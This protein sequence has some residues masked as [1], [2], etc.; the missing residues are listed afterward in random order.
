[1]GCDMSVAIRKILADARPTRSDAIVKL[2]TKVADV[3]AELVRAPGVLGIDLFGSV[4]RGDASPLSDID[5]LVVA[6]DRSVRA[7]ELRRLVSPR[8][9]ERLSLHVFSSGRFENR[10][11]TNALFMTHLRAEG[12]VLYDPFR[13]IADALKQTA[14]VSVTARELRLV[15]ARLRAYDDA[16]RFG[17][18]YLLPLSHLY[19]LGKRAAMLRLHEMS[20]HEYGPLKVFET[21]RILVPSAD[22]ATAALTELRPFNHLVTGRPSEALPY[23]FHNAR[24]QFEAAVRAVAD[25]ARG[26]SL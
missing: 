4:A 8:L 12:I 22:A 18:D 10:S 15:L 11:R 3:T 24:R 17:D 16:S 23:D 7:T 25:V 21:L 6:R 9:R 1:M 19:V 5:V 14:R 2:D 13:V 26:D 20:V